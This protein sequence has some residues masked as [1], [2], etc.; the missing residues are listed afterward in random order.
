MRIRQRALLVAFV[1][2]LWAQDAK[3]STGVDVVTLLATVRDAQGL[4]AKKISR[5]DFVL[6]EDGVPQTIRYSSRES[7]L[8]LTIGLLVD[9]N[10]SQLYVWSRSA[11]Q[12]TSSS[13]RSCARAR[14]RHSSR[15]ST[16]RWKCCKALP[17]RGKISS[18]RSAYCRFP[19]ALGR[20][21]TTRSGTAPRIG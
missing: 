6:Q 16:F 12:A 2:H 18:R 8:P 15:I 10:N 21:F 4:L 7:D 3:F 14:T 17:R 9:T 20:C 1:C 5:D 11:G 19:G 13:T